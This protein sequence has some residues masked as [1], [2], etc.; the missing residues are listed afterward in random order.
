M[1]Q[2]VYPWYIQ[3]Q[4]ICYP[5]RKQKL[6]ASISLYK[7]NKDH[8]QNYQTWIAIICRKETIVSINEK[9]TFVVNLKKNVWYAKFVITRNKYSYRVEN[10]PARIYHNE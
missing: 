9:E 6:R 4:N 5:N 3:P 10:F 1:M 2:T 8:L 7:K